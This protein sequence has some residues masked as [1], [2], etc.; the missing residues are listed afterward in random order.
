MPAQRGPDGRAYQNLGGMVNQASGS[1][2][3][4]TNSITNSTRAS[5]KSSGM[6]KS[7][8][9]VAMAMGTSMLMTGGPIGKVAGALTRLGPA[10]QVAGAAL[11]VVTAVVEGTVGALMSMAS[12]AIDVVQQRSKLLA[13]FSALGGG[14]AQGAKT[15][16][17]VDELATKLPFTTD[18]IA[19]WAQSLQSAGIQGSKL[20]AAVS[21][22]ASATAL[23]GESGGAAAERMV[24]QLAEGGQASTKLMKQIQEGSPKSAKMLAAM[25]LQVKD[26]AAAAGMTESA[27]KKAHLSADQMSKAVEKALE[28]KGAGPLAEMGQT[29]PVIFSKVKEG[30]MGLFEKLGP[31]VKPFM[32]AV[33]KLFAQFNKGSPIFKAL[34]PIVTQVFGTLFKYATMA[35]TA[36]SKFIK[37]NVNAKSI[38]GVW[39]SIKAAIKTVGDALRPIGVKFMAIVHNAATMKVIKTI[40]T[41]IAGAVLAAIYVFA[42]LIGVSLDVIGAIMSF[43]GAVVDGA[44][45]LVASASSVLSAVSDFVDGAVDSLG[46][47]ASGATDAASDFVDGL[48]GGIEAGAGQVIAAVAGLASSALASF[49]SILGIASPSKV[50]AKMGG[51]FSAGTAQG[52]DAGADKV[53]DSAAA[54]GGVAAGGAAGGMSK[55]GASAGGKGGVHISGGVNITVPMGT[56]AAWAEEA[57]AAFMERLAASQGV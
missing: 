45:W 55:G 35:V 31:A 20:K 22:I 56:P 12:A 9:K 26:V 52:I 15:L 44:S 51:H 40:F 1:L 28:K 29:F 2:G 16:K 33:Q 11:L 38:G 25:G 23:M 41:L 53:G 7:V 6:L 8:S 32:A 57:F 36:V 54:L 13:T 46:D 34:Q 4:F 49:K 39:N 24:K 17:V 18:V 10:G 43:F 50:M 14:A 42:Y 27:F 30:A 48:V 47:L 5:S 3:K 21:A 19:G 37:S